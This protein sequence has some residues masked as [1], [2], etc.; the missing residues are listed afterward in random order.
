MTYTYQVNANVLKGHNK[1]TRMHFHCSIIW[2]ISTVRRT[3]NAETSTSEK[4]TNPWSGSDLTAATS[5]SPVQL[6]IDP[7]SEEISERQRASSPFSLV[8]NDCGDCD[9]RCRAEPQKNSAR[10][11]RKSN[12]GLFRQ[13]TQVRHYWLYSLPSWYI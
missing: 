1:F 2:V 9:A 3:A 7:R 4:T 13:T 6:P 10:R 12:Y 11:G 8:R 5:E